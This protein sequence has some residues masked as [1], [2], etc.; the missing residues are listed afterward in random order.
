MN[1]NVTYLPG[2]EKDKFLSI[3]IKVSEEMVKPLLSS[4][5]LAKLPSATRDHYHYSCYLICHSHTT[6]GRNT[7]TN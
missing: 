7:G 1:I 6:F 3:K 5:Q 2:H 4:I